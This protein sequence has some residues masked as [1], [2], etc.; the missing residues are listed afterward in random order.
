MK[1]K[2]SCE[3]WLE[4][5][6]WWTHDIPWSMMVQNSCAA[7]A[8]SGYS[9]QPM[10]CVFDCWWFAGVVALFG[11]CS[12][13]GPKTQILSFL[14][15]PTG[16]MQWYFKILHQLSQVKGGYLSFVFTRI[17]TS[18]SSFRFFHLPFSWRILSW[19]GQNQLIH[20]IHHLMFAGGNKGHCSPTEDAQRI[21]HRGQSFWHGFFGEKLMSKQKH[22][23]L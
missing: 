14:L 18:Q 1:L 11:G 19:C 6:R 9:N 12:I 22:D 5:R 23:G 10:P 4:K 2:R 20:L 17:E 21:R 3:W 16:P 7:W 8:Y 13:E 15:S